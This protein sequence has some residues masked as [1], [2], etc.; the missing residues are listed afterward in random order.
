MNLN[1]QIKDYQRKFSHEFS[2]QERFIIQEMNG[3]FGITRSTALNDILAKSIDY[4]YNIISDGSPY[5]HKKNLDFNELLLIK[6]SNTTEQGN[7]VKYTSLNDIRNNLKTEREFITNAESSSITLDMSQ[8]YYFRVLANSPSVNI[9]FSGFNKFRVHEIYIEAVD[10][11]NKDIQWIDTINTTV[12]LQNG[13]LDYT[14]LQPERSVVDLL[15]VIST[16]AGFIVLL[17]AK[18]I[19]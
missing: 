6:D 7:Q 5:P 12:K 1:K 11:F 2:G 3:N 9:K 19:F 14:P 17:E 10:F 16:R 4:T 8:Y 18:D 13:V 15:K